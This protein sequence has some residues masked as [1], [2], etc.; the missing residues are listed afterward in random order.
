MDGF[1]KS[2]NGKS[3]KFT[4]LRLHFGLSFPVLFMCLKI[5]YIQWLLAIEK[6]TNDFLRA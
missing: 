1:G 4:P 6:L 2:V 3:Q 5:K